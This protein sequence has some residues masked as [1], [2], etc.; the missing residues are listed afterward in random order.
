MARVGGVGFGEVVMLACLSVRLLLLREDTTCS[1][2]F[3]GWMARPLRASY[4]IGAALVEGGGSACAAQSTVVAWGGRESPS[5]AAFSSPS[6][7]G[8]GCECSCEA[9]MV[10]LRRR[11]GRTAVLARPDGEA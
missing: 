7:S 3:G 6:T 4:S 5:R 1:H 10:G 11:G 2:G 8:V 9:C